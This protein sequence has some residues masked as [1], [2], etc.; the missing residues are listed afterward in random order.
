VSNDE[1]CAIE[2]MLMNATRIELTLG[3][4]GKLDSLD[5]AMLDIL[6]HGPHVSQTPLFQSA[7]LCKG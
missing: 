4:Y 5:V 2:D 3:W 6:S 1:L 7:R